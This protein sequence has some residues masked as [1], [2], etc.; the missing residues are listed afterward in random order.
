MTETRLRKQYKQLQD[1]VPVD[2]SQVKE[3]P[4][5]DIIAGTA[6]R[7]PT[8]QQ[9]HAALDTRCDRMAGWLETLPG[10]HATGMKSPT[11]LIAHLALAAVMEGM[12]IKRSS[13]GLTPAAAR[14]EREANRASSCHQPREAHISPAM[15]AHLDRLDGKPQMMSGQRL[16]VFQ[17]G[18]QT[19]TGYLKSVTV[20]EAAA[21][22]AV[23][24]LTPDMHEKADWKLSTQ[25]PDFHCSAQDGT[26]ATSSWQM[27]FQSPKD[28]SGSP[29]PMM[30]ASPSL[31]WPALPALPTIW[32]YW[33]L[34]TGP[35]PYS[36]DALDI[37]GNKT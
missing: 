1:S 2:F 32:R 8:F 12:S 4:C 3:Q 27:S 35:T 37:T 20:T 30:K 33:A 36:R 10:D 28:A 25:C 31:A 22:A 23:K 9:Q 18:G 11:R 6:L 21:A 19:Q 29:L 24:H 26:A 16:T 14:W 13:S 7:V 5:R 15:P 34:E 17:A